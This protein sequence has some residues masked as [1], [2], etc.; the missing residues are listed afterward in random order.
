LIAV[1]VAWLT[2]CVT[3]LLPE[4]ERILDDFDIALSESTK[5]QYSLA[6][7]IVNYG[8]ALLVAAVMI[9]LLLRLW[10]GRRLLHYMRAGIP[11]FGKLWLFESLAELFQV[12][13]ML[14]RSGVSLPDA[15]VWASDAVGDQS[16][17]GSAQRLAQGIQAGIPI[18]DAIAQDPAFPEITAAILGWGQRSGA[19]EIAFQEAANVFQDRV[20]LQLSLTRFL[21]PPFAFIGVAAIVV[22]IVST[23]VGQLTALIRALSF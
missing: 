17:A 18:A 12:T 22:F 10:G 6:Y 1:L 9:A 2:F 7:G 3:Y 14:L 4:F 8:L 16:L 23:T 5:L 13:A 11:L 19:L 15:L 21:V 20:E